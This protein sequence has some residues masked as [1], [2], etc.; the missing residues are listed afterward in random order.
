MISLI[1]DPF[2]WLERR[3]PLAQWRVGGEELVDEPRAEAGTGARHAQP[4][5]LAPVRRRCRLELDE[6]AAQPRGVRVK[7]TAG[8]PASASRLRDTDAWSM[9]AAIS[10]RIAA[11]LAI[12]A[13]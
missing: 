13:S 1:T 9:T 7:E 2:E 6:R 3:D 5:M 4:R 8:A 12:F 10:A 11:T